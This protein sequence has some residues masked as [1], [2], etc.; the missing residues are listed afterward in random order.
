MQYYA[1]YAADLPPMQLNP[2]QPNIC[3]T[4]FT[5]K[6]QGRIFRLMDVS[7]EVVKDLLG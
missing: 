3:H 7:A 2:M 1:T 6:F 4:R 5:Y